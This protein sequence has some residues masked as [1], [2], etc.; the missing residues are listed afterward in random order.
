MEMSVV[1]PIYNEEEILKELYRRISKVLKD[2]DYEI[3]FVDDGSKDKTFS[4]LRGLCQKD[5]RLNVIRL[6]ENF[7]QQAALLAGIKESKGEI[8]I[9]M[10]GDLQNQPEEIPKFLEKIEEGFYVVKGWREKRKSNLFL[11]KLP[12]FFLNYLLNKGRRVKLHDYGCG[13]LTFRREVI[14][15]LGNPNQN[16]HT[17]Y[18][19]GSFPISEIKI[20]DLPRRKGRSRYTILKLVSTFLELVFSF[21]DEK[22]ALGFK[23][24][25]V[26]EQPYSIKEVLKSK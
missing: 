20:K 4:I 14:N 12:S 16:I 21:A 6:K 13:F 19:K 15:Q 8:I 3:I 24:M 2:K 23:K 11:R 5:R 9:T 25:F 22:W 1:I 26:K 17:F 7:G 18:I 10:D